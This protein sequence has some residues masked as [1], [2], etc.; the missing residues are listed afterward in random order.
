MHEST[1]IQASSWIS[2]LSD[3]GSFMGDNLSLIIAFLALLVTILSNVKTNNRLRH[4]ERPVISITNMTVQKKEGTFENAFG[5][6]NKFEYTIVIYLKNIGKHSAV[7]LKTSTW[8]LWAGLKIHETLDSANR[9][10]FDTN[11]VIT[12]K[13]FTKEEVTEENKIFVITTLEYEDYLQDNNSLSP[14]RRWDVIIGD[15]SHRHATIEEKDVVEQL[16]AEQ[17]IKNIS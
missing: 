4:F 15:A 11:F 7:N 13:I 3:I 8:Y 1:I 12:K 6:D 17:L 14:E 9:I 16:I 5:N 2:Y 10:D